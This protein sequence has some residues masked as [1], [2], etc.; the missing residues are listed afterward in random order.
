[1]KFLQNSRILLTKWWP[2]IL[3]L[4]ILLAQFGG[5]LGSSLPAGWDTLPHY[6][7]LQ[8]M[9]D[10]LP[11][12]KITGYDMN[13]F[14]GFPLF[15]FYGPLLPMLIAGLYLLAGKLLALAF[16]YRLAILLSL[17]AFV[18]SFVWFVITWWGRKLRPWAYLVAL[19]F[20]FYPKLL[21]NHALG[22]GASII[23]GMF[24]NLYGIALFLLFLTLLRRWERFRNMRDWWWLVVIGSATV[25]TH[26]LTTIALLVT[27]LL[28]C[29]LRWRRRLWLSM[30]KLA[31]LVFLLTAWWLIPFGK[32]LPYASSATAIALHDYLFLLF[33]WDWQALLHGQWGQLEWLAA[34]VFVCGIFGLVKLIHSRQYIWPSF[35]L[36]WLLI[37]ASRYIVTFAPNFPLHY[38]RLFPFVYVIFLAMAAFGLSSLWQWSRAYK[39]WRGVGLAL[40]V[41]VFIY[42]IA[43]HYRLAGGSGQIDWRY[44]RWD[45]PY[46]FALDKYPAAQ[47]ARQ[48]TDYLAT[49]P[50]RQR[51]LVEQPTTDQ[52][53]VGSPHYFKTILPLQGQ[54]VPGGLYIEG[55]IESPLFSPTWAVV[56]DSFTWGEMSLYNDPTFRQQ[57]S[58]SML[59]RLQYFGVDTVVAIS[60]KL[61]NALSAFSSAKLIYSLQDYDVYELSGSMPFVYSAHYQPGIYFSNNNLSFRDLVKIW[62]KFPLL[63]DMPIVEARTDL[64]TTQSA[65]L[66]KFAYIMVNG[67]LATGDLEQLANASGLIIWLNAP[68]PANIPENMRSHLLFI[69]DFSANPI[70]GG[71]VKLARE[72]SK[73]RE[74]WRLSPQPVE[75]IRQDNEKLEFSASGPTIIN[76][77][78]FPYWQD[79][80]GQEVYQTTP[81]SQ[82]LVWANGDTNLV[83]QPDKDKIFSRWVSIMTLLVVLL[84][85]LL[86]RRKFQL[87]IKKLS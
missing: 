53:W 71:P 31:G 60:D 58:D 57:S 83:Y 37:L 4:V 18:Y 84:Y 36:I 62:Y 1:M 19:S 77:G 26:T 16:W 25:L 44:L 85:W 10:W 3:V 49:L 15:Q 65:E 35:L 70:S 6:Y 59:E 79:Q 23:D 39:I 76:F 73:Y 55:A 45:S 29:L 7:G 13:W 67:S 21:S 34:A 50:D 8:K 42:T 72:L 46:Y 68:N 14:S 41:F 43:W 20:L 30:A 69:D 5:L 80:S 87:V 75:M 81:A 11:Q 51:I 54:A 78:Y 28:Y 86:G 27:V 52:G 17:L 38:Y 64:A 61:K 74:A 66:E 47:E 24:V 32:G 40:L 9:A 63:L 56:S 12:G 48:L 22:A 82:M 2:H 33:P